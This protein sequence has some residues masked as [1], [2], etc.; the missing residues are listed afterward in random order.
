MVVLVEEEAVAHPF[1]VDDVALDGEALQHPGGPLVEL[2]GCSEL[3]RAVPNSLA[4]SRRVSHAVSSSW[5]TSMLA[6]PSWPVKIKNSA[7]ELRI[8]WPEGREGPSSCMGP[9][10]GADDRRGQKSLVSSI[11]GCARVLRLMYF[12]GVSCT[13]RR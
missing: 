9:C 11:Y 8:S 13:F 2:G 6:P 3:V 1:P 4:I 12:P 5:R 10:Y 7:V